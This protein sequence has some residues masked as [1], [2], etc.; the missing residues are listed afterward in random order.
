M[1]LEAYKSGRIRQASQDGNREFI[2]LL[3]CVSAIGKKVPATLLYKGESYDLQDTWMEDLEDTDDFFFGASSNRWSNNAFGL[4]WLTKVFDPATRTTTRQGKRLLI[5]D[6]HLSH[7]NMAFINKCWEL[8][9]ILLILPPHSTHRLQP[10]DVVLFGQLST[11]YSNELNA[12]QNKGLSLT[13]M[14]KR[15]FL[16]IFRAAWRTAF[17]KENIQRAFEK[18]GIWPYNPSLVL[19]VITRPSTPPQA[20]KAPSTSSPALKTPMDARSIRHFQADY[21]KNPTQAKL[22]KLFKAN[23]QLAAQAALDQHTK[24][25]LINALK[26]EKKCHNRGKRLNV[27]GEEHNGPILFSTANVMRAQAVAAE[28]EEKEKQERARID[29]NKAAT[30]LKKQRIEAEKAQKALQAAVRSDNQAEVEAEE[31]AEKQA[32]KKKE[33]SV[34]KALK[35]PLVKTKAP[36]KAKKAPVC[37]KIVVRFASNDVEEVVPAEATKSSISGRVIKKPVV[38]E[39]GT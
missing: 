11:A 37:E 10:L 23:E 31:K 15:H 36:I 35:D 19:L 17:T 2:S 30:A 16:A 29:A 34:K 18:P 12:F 24:E 13:S 22:Q 6:G 27:L 21:L 9:I 3:A 4:Q 33:V 25:G 32:Q 20:I 5:V 1:S 39:K 26:T 7:I 8:R 28:K 38:F 14:K